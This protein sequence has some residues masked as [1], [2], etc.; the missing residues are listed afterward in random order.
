MAQKNPYSI[1]LSRH[2]TE[3][4]HVLQSLH[5]NTSNPSVKKCNTP[6]YVFIVD[7]RASKPAI[8]RAVEEIYS[9][10]KVRVIAV[11]TINVKPKACRMR[12]RKGVKAGFKKAIVTLQPG[13]VIEEKV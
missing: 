3:K 7:K 1:I 5:T 10:F 9:E 4:A 11:N 12:G 8:A 2:V 13:D 6:K